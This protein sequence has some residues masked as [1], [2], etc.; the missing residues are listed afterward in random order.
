VFETNFWG[1]YN[2]CKNLI[3]H[4]REN[5]NGTIINCS[6][7]MGLVPRVMGVAYCSSKHALEGLTSCL[8]LE[9]RKFCRVMSV[10]PGLFPSNMIKKEKK[11]F[12]TEFD[13][14]KFPY[15]NIIK[16][17]RNYRNDTSIA[18]NNLIDIVEKE[19]IPR[20]LLLGKD[21]IQRVK[22]EIKT[23]LNDIK[24]SNKV[25]NKIA[26][27]KKDKRFRIYEK[28]DYVIVNFW[29]TRNYGASMTAWAMEQ[30]V[31]SFGFT[32]LTLNHNDISNYELYNKSFSKRF[33]N[34]FLHLSEMYSNKELKIFSKNAKG[35]ILGSDQVLRVNYIKKKLYKYLLN[36][37]DNNTKKIALSASFG[38]NLEQLKNELK[39]DNETEKYMSKALSSFDYLSTRELSGKEIYKNIFNLDSEHILDP[40]FLIDKNEYSK[41]TSCSNIDNKNKIV[42]YV[43]DDNQEYLQ[44]YNLVTNGKEENVIKINKDNFEVEDWLKTIQDCKFLITDSF[45]GACFALIF[46]KPFICIRN[47]ERGDARFESLI[48]MFNVERNF[49]Y[50]I[51]ELVNKD[52]N[53]NDYKIDITEKLENVKK[54]DLKIVEKVLKYDYKNNLYSKV[55]KNENYVFLKKQ[56]FH[57][58]KTYLKYFK[59]RLLCNVTFGSKKQH[60]K[61]KKSYYKAVLKSGGM[62]W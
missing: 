42:S 33:A 44:L 9:T 35:V 21:C 10:E 48:T 23:I 53:L 28:T 61:D 30:L 59:Y 26:I 54:K 49:I 38:V 14:Y 24:I 37:V 27:N 25:S 60:Y 4:F 20:R 55:G 58:I 34:K 52:F 5:K 62:L 7:V 12:V 46:G 6:S 40:V 41:I 47:K 16:V 2:T 36:W 13:E 31:K 43:L 29:H 22:Y 15:I 17:V 18:M 45:H 51:Q 11:A 1:T 57:S 56:K 3:S 50:S 8:W 19:K 32:C 39:F